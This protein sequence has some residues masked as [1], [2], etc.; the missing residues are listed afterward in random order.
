MAIEHLP[1]QYLVALSSLLC[2]TYCKKCRFFTFYF[3]SNKK[4]SQLTKSF[5]NSGISVLFTLNCDSGLWGLGW[6]AVLRHATFLYSFVYIKFSY[7]QPDT[8]EQNLCCIHSR[9]PVCEHM[10]KLSPS[11]CSPLEMSLGDTGA[12]REEAR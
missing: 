11:T 12:R 3:L 1:I 4:A 10:G 5:K 2:Q 7:P 9:T 6:Q 8:A